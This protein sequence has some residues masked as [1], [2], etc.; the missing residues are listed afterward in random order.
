MKASKRRVDCLELLCTDLHYIC[1]LVNWPIK[2]QLDMLENI[3]ILIIIGIRYQV[4]QIWEY[5]QEYI[6]QNAGDC[7]IPE[8]IAILKTR[9]SNGYIG[10]ILFLIEMPLGTSGNSQ[11]ITM[12]VEGNSE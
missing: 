9:I 12:C 1:K 3:F 8:N 7:G 10:R 11:Y 4:I 6:L 2:T 5:I